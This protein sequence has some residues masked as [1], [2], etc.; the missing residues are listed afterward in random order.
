MKLR[1]PSALLAATFAASI[2]SAPTAQAAASR[3]QL[4]FFEKKIRP[5]L[6]ENCYKCHSIAEGKKRGELTLD[7]REGSVKGGELGPAIVPGDLDKSLLIKA[8]RYN[9]EDLQ[10]PPKTKLSSAQIAD[11][12]AWVKMG[13]PDPRDGKLIA[14]SP[15]DIAK[16]HWAFQPIKKPA[17]PSS[18]NR[19]WEKTEIDNFILAELKKNRMAPSKAADKRTLIRR[20]TYDLIGLPP[21]IPDFEAFMVDSSPKAFEKVVD[22]LLD[23]P[24]YGERWGRYWLDVAR[25]S[26]TK[27]DVNNN[28]EDY[29]YPYAWT[30]RDYVVQSFNEDKPYNEFIKEQLAADLMLKKGLVR[31]NAL[32]AL[33]FITVGK[34]FGGNRNDIIDDR[35]DVVSKGFLGLTVVCARCHDHKFDPI[36]TADYYAWHGVF[37]SIRDNYEDHEL[38]L[39]KPVKNTRDYFAYAKELNELQQEH[40]KTRFKEDQRIR[41][42]AREKAGTYLYATWEVAQPTNTINQ[43]IF[44]GTERKLHSG[45]YG[46]WRNYLATKKKDD[47]LFGPWKAYSALKAGDWRSDKATALNGK[48]SAAKDNPINT[49]LARAIRANPPSSMRAVAAIYNKLFSD[50]DALWQKTLASNGRSRREPKPL[51]EHYEQIRAVLYGDERWAPASPDDSAMFGLFSQ[52]FQ[53]RLQRIK[54]RMVALKMSHDGAPG[55]AMVVSDNGNGRNSK[56]FIRGDARNQGDE[57]PR[58][59][60]EALSDAKPKPFT[61]GSGRWDLAEAIA[62]RDNPLTARVIVNR[63]WM[64]HF[65]EGIVRT[66]S[67]F[68]TRCDPPSHPELLDWMATWFMD[69]GWSIKKLH[70]L[71]MMSS[72]YQLTS[73]DDAR[74]SQA[75]PSNKLHYRYNVRRLDF[76]AMRDTLL[77]IGGK[78]D[79]TVGGK[80][81]DLMDDPFPTRRTIYGMVDRRSLASIFNTFDFANPDLSTAQRYQTT[82]P[83]QALFL[84]NNPLVAEQARNLTARGDFRGRV[85]E[86]ERVYLL[87]KLIYQRAPN[88]RELSLAKRYLSTQGSLQL[89]AAFEAP[90]Q[91][92]AGF[93]DALARK[94]TKFSKMPMFHEEQEAWYGGSQLKYAY[95]NKDGGHAGPPGVAVIRRWTAQADGTVQV[96]GALRHSEELGDG[97][98]GRIV[99][100]RSGMLGQWAVKNRSQSTTINRHTV[101]KG[102]TID[103]IVD[104]FKVPGAD[105]FKWAPVVNMLSVRDPKQLP[106]GGSTTWNAQM[107]FTGPRKTIDARPLQAWEK[108]AQV[109]L[110]TNELTF[111]N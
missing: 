90:W 70:K 34:K 66:P 110:L 95:L 79:L 83:Q 43:F 91:Y 81:V 56:I 16:K 96:N 4:D 14:S 32:A 75:D 68:G 103:F 21:T 105:E 94:V 78:I 59:F 20:A 63:V 39:L 8:V 85:S 104:C 62:S 35:I 42:D 18:I 23:S 3:E 101:T 74:K 57:V 76:E 107:M 72:V 45:I 87:Y 27:G 24:H 71:I 106:P 55:R 7:T 47:P 93:Y 100:S 60:L 28:R 11:L 17:V 2:L 92:G 22:R 53:G 111:Y 102:D 44:I 80:P 58:R 19:S 36:P 98:I 5:I 33:G 69:N 82:V 61:N 1:L 13:A 38:P 46:R 15:R 37:N 89:E 65:G 73:E 50:V 26:D 67:D 41:K 25:Y 108:F 9:D 109:L 77:Q 10:M 84:M 97:I 99:S 30:Y 54:G 6:A 40:A 52:G 64:Q 88:P 51:A 86:D 31:T 48:H 12:E 49:P 29:R